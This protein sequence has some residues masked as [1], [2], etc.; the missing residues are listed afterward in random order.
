MTLVTTGVR[1]LLNEG[2]RITDYRAGIEFA[3]SQSIYRGDRLK[4][5][6][7]KSDSNPTVL[8]AVFL[9]VEISLILLRCSVLLMAM[10]QRWG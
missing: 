8:L 7:Q 3:T 9:P 5:Q 10:N 4:T 6:S 1:L 2:S